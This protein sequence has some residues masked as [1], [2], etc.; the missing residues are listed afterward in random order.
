VDYDIATQAKRITDLP[1]EIARVLAGHIVISAEQG[2]RPFEGLRP[3]PR[4]FA[5][6]FEHSETR[7]ESLAPERIEFRLPKGVARIPAPELRVAELV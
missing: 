2:L 6:M 3:A 1:Y 4:R 5:E 7:L